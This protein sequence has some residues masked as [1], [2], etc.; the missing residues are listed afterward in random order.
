MSCGSQAVPLQPLSSRNTGKKQKVSTPRKIPVAGRP[1]NKPESVS[2][3]AVRSSGPTRLP[4]AGSS[5][6]LYQP[7][8]HRPYHPR[9]H[10]AAV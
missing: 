10:L 3:L 9:S 2:P 5:L 7:P 4:D 8:P 1:Q 6:S